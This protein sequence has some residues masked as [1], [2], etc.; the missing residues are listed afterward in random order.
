MK[1]IKRV[2]GKERLIRL[3]DYNLI[4]IIKVFNYFDTSFSD[5]L[6]DGDNLIYEQNDKDNVIYVYKK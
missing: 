3:K 6:K 2:C 1:I 4:A 5:Y